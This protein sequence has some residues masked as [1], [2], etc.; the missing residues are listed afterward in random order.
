MK[1]RVGSIKTMTV[2]LFLV[3]ISNIMIGPA[4]PLEYYMR[5]DDSARFGV[6]VVSLA[7]GGLGTA[8]WV[9]V[10]LLLFWFVVLC[11]SCWF[12]LTQNTQQQC[13]CAHSTRH[14]AFCVSSWS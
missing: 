3:A 14:D 11:L 5:S 9:C 8:W 4:P 1:H 13:I 12:V 7:L 2:G 6:L 10:L